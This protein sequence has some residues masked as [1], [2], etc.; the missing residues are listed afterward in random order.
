MP[1]LIFRDDCIT[2]LRLFTNFDRRILG[3]FGHLNSQT[4]DQYQNTYEGEFK[5][6]FDD[7]F[8]ASIITGR[9]GRPSAFQGERKIEE[10]DSDSDSVSKLHDIK[11]IPKSFRWTLPQAVAVSTRLKFS[12]KLSLNI[13]SK[14][15]L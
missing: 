10:S 14:R 9:M 15:G 12:R 11:F 5:A 1:Y 4:V 2:N 7:D 8:L 3:P 6:K 13:C